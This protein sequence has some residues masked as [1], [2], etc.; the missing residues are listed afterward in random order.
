MLA[1]FQ[2]WLGAAKT[3]RDSHSGLQLVVR[4]QRR[5]EHLQSRPR[6]Y[7]SDLDHQYLEPGAD[8]NR[9]IRRVLQP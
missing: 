3:H 7:A 9:S 1:S 2:A 4:A 8:A 5:Q 6:Q